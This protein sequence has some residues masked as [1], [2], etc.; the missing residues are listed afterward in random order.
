MVWFVTL[1][2]FM[3]TNRC[4]TRTWLTWTHRWQASIGQRSIKVA[5]NQTDTTTATYSR[6]LTCK[7]Q[8]IPVRSV[9]CDGYIAGLTR[10]IWRT[11]EPIYVHDTHTAVARMLPDQ[12][13]TKSTWLCKVLGKYII[14]LVCNQAIVRLLLRFILYIYSL[15]IFYSY[16]IIFYILTCKIERW[17]SRERDRG[18]EAK[19]QSSSV[20]FTPSFA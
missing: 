20:E 13:E 14:I 8:L 16:Y 5:V 18:L 3:C 10:A 7:S 1:A 6:N 2:R 19:N 9:A 15:F 4:T 12:N 11:H 17:R